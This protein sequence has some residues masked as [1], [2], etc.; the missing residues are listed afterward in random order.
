[1]KKSLACVAVVLVIEGGL[2]GLVG[3]ARPAIP[4]W[5][6]VGLLLLPA[7][8]VVML[9]GEEAAGGRWGGYAGAGLRAAAVGYLLACLLV[10]VL[11][12]AGPRPRGWPLLSA[13]VLAGAAVS[14]RMLTRRDH[15]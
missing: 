15:K 4:T 5:L 1:M 9:R 12:V 10:G 14:L 7:A 11:A 13:F 6:A 8:A 2:A 3:E